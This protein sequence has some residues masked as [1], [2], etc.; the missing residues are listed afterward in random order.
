[1]P[2][3]QRSLRFALRSAALALALVAAAPADG[4]AVLSLLAVRVDGDPTRFLEQV[5]HASAIRARLGVATLNVLQATFAG[6]RTGTYFVSAE[7]PSLAALG[8]ASDALAADAEWQA[9]LQQLRTLGR[10]EASSL[11][12]DRTPPGVKPT[13]IIPGGYVTGMTVR[14]EP[15]PAAYLALLPRLT[16]NFARLGA[17]V[18]RIWQATSAGTDTGEILITT[19]Q[20]SLAALE[21]SQRKLEADPEEQK[22]LGEIE[23]TGRHVITRMLARDRTPH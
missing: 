8:E 6:D 17:S 13:P 23:A 5:K 11:Y 14:T 10:V 16:A 4:A 1:M 2:A 3:V 15:D 18:P 7:Y 9:T 19:A 12:V 21:E 22:L 20:P